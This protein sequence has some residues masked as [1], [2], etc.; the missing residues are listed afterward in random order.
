MNSRI[1]EKI[2]QLRTQEKLSQETLAEK[3]GVSRQAIS[4]WERDEALPDLYNIQSLANVFH[5]S[6]DELIGKSDESNR[7]NQHDGYD[8]EMKHTGNYIKKLL[9]KAKHTTNTEEAKKIKKILIISGSIGLVVGIS[10]VL[11]GFISFGVGAQNSVEEMG[12]GT[13][14]FNPLP[15]IFIFLVGGIISII[16]VYALY[17]GF[18]IFVASVATN[19]LDTREKCPQ[20]GNEIDSDEKVCSNCGYHLQETI[21]CTCGK[22]NQ[23]GDKYCRSCGKK[24][25]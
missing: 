24:L 9:L 18:T 14:P 8:D 16:S 15:Y 7:I 23:K 13:T 22:E 5:V 3:I 19:Y 2:Y 12:F 6:V 20:C 25:F 4:K 1:G 11:F 17:G 10:M 21:K